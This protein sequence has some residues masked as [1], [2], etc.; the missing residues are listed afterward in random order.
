MLSH[1]HKNWND[2]KALGI[3][4]PQLRK[5]QGQWLAQIVRSL[6]RQGLNVLVEVFIVPG[7]DS[8][9]Q[10]VFQ[11]IL[12]NKYMVEVADCDHFD[13]TWAEM[14]ELNPFIQAM[15]LSEVSNVNLATELAA[16][17]VLPP[18][19]SLHEL[20]QLLDKYEVIRQRAKRATQCSRAWQKAYDQLLENLTAGG[21]LS[22]IDVASAV[23][24]AESHLRDLA[25]DPQAEEDSIAR[26][27]DRHHDT[28]CHFQS[29][30]MVQRLK[31][32]LAQADQASS[33]SAQGPAG[34]K[35]AFPGTPR[36]PPGKG[37]P[38]HSACATGVP[39]CVGCEKSKQGCCLK[40]EIE[41]K[42][43]WY[44][45][46][47]VKLWQ[48]ESE[49]QARAEQSAVQH[50]TNLESEVESYGC[51][52]DFE[53]DLD[54]NEDNFAYSLLYWNPDSDHSRPAI[55]IVHQAATFPLH[56][57]ITDKACMDT[58]ANTSVAN[59]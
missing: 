54:S 22:L 35:T 41:H 2:N 31:A 9:L 37:P 42:K 59:W 16:V 32:R 13:H 50:T 45:E 53:S 25:H 11:G 29:A 3:T 36:G 49:R 12:T 19:T 52:S 6:N 24:L 4:A 43:L 18:S 26:S 14:I 27:T 34:A 30:M 48:Y 7:D 57:P 5:R 1:F 33:V 58:G 39:G 44:A 8:S 15:S 51:A 28:Q 17:L 40:H 21:L 23:A 10:D 56:D 46:Q 47:E 38:T 20:T 55:P